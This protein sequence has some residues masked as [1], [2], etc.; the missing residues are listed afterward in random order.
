MKSQ[1]FTLIF[2]FFSS[3]FYAQIDIKFETIL[4]NGKQ[5]ESAHLFFFDD[6]FVCI[7][8]S[9]EDSILQTPNVNEKVFIFR[10]L[11]YNGNIISIKKFQ[12][13]TIS[14]KSYNTIESLEIYPI[15]YKNKFVIFTEGNAEDKH[16]CNFGEYGSEP[17]S[18]YTFDENFNFI[19]KS[20]LCYPITMAIN[21]FKQIGNR[22]FFTG[23]LAGNNWLTPAILSYN[24]ITKET[25]ENYY[26]G[27]G[28]IKDI[29]ITN[30][31][32][33][34]FG[35]K[36]FPQ[37]LGTCVTNSFMGNNWLCKTDYNLN[38]THSHEFKFVNRM[39]PFRFEKT[40]G[41]DNDYLMFFKRDNYH[42]SGFYRYK[43]G[44]L[45]F[46]NIDKSY[47]NLIN[48]FKDDNSNIYLIRKH[49]K[50]KTCY[51]EATRNEKTIWKYNIADYLVDNAKVIKHKDTYY[52]TTL[53]S[54]PRTLTI[55]ALTI[56]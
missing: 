13:D 24:L 22:V 55:K 9:L 35:F 51:I 52:L 27:Y 28:I 14:I 48:Y 56:N 21:R 40:G 47:N 23:F 39:I 42:T 36:F 5:D 11:D 12:H 26:D 8:Y 6:Y 54:Y 10:K 2:L 29:I 17:I 34:F 37:C 1:L 3:V 32:Y 4:E 38:L 19:S 49:D 18:V 16:E 41:T 20:S 53:S 25:S 33:E 46:T 31:G 15:F 43:S 44:S 50:N 7:S 45:V 30:S